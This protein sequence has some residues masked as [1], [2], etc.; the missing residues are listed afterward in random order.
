MVGSLVPVS[1]M[2]R[3]TISIDCS[4]AERLRASS[5]TGCG[6]TV[7]SPPALTVT[8][9][10]GSA[11]AMAAR[12]D[13]VRAAIAQREGNVIALHAEIGVAD[14]ARQHGAAQFID[15]RA[16][17]V[18]LDRRHIDFEQQMRAA[19]QIQ[20]QADL[21]MRQEGRPF[22]YGLGR[23]GVG[24][25]EDHTQGADAQDENDLPGLKIEHEPLANWRSYRPSSAAAGFRLPAR[26]HRRRSPPYCR[27]GR[28]APAR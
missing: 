5:A 21:A 4:T 26:P 8:S 11:L 10:S 22:R 9:T 14:M 24:Q 6:R 15:Q 27:P 28:C 18:A 25:R 20:P 23:E 2:R 17:T 3:R 7:M 12:L 13:D 16:E 1:S 19:A